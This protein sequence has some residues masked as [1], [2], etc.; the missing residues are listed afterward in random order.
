[1]IKR[2][3][4]CVNCDLPCIYSA[5]PYYEV[6]NYYCDECGKE[7]AVYQ[8]DDQDLCESCF[9]KYLE[10][11]FGYLST[12]EKAELLEINYKYIG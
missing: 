5:C 8:I 6:E 3:N 10:E 2:T 1:M 4:E 11:E 9:E 7:S 12:S